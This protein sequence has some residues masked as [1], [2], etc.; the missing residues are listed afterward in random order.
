[1]TNTL[2]R[3]ASQPHVL[4]NHIYKGGIFTLLNT[5]TREHMC[6]KVKTGW[7]GTGL[8]KRAVPLVYA[9]VVGN[10][11]V[12]VGE[13]IEQGSSMSI[14]AVWNENDTYLMFAKFWTALHYKD[15]PINIDFWYPRQCGKCKRLLTDPDSIRIG[16]GPK[17]KLSMRT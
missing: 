5:T 14:D 3:Y 1:M 15:I 16:F 2:F 11:F 17:C 12:M 9:K 7:T 4:I 8:Q 10:R 6:Y 13:I